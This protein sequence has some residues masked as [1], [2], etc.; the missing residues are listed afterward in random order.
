MAD[1]VSDAQLGRQHTRCTDAAAT[2]PVCLCA[3]TAAGQR[4]GRHGV[5]APRPPFDAVSDTSVESTPPVRRRRRRDLSLHPDRRWVQPH[6]RTAAVLNATADSTHAVGAPTP[7]RPVSASGMPPAPT[8]RAAPALGSPTRSQTPA[9]TPTA[10]SSRPALVLEPPISPMS[11]TSWTTQPRSTKPPTPQTRVTLPAVDDSTPRAA[12]LFGA[13]RREGIHARELFCA[14]RRAAAGRCANAM[15][16]ELARSLH[17]LTRSL[18][19]ADAPALSGRPRSHRRRLT[20]D[21]VE[22][23]RAARSCERTI[24]GH[25]FSVRIRHHDVICKLTVLKNCRSSFLPSSSFF[26][27]SPA[28]APLQIWAKSVRWGKRYVPMSDFSAD[29]YGS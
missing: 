5:P 25:T 9:S 28:P 21:D 6:A 14:S 11:P 13:S 27:A 23:E 15:G 1:A 3:R 20:N 4:R 24:S 22:R 12:R 7:P 10:R 2:I 19:H 29:P 8:P 16:S 26:G 17:S 18:A